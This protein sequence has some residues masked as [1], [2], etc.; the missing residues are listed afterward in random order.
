MST[1][2]ESREVTYDE[3]R[4]AIRETGVLLDQLRGLLSYPNLDTLKRDPNENLSYKDE[5][6]NLVNLATEA[7]I[8]NQDLGRQV[9]WLEEAASL[10]VGDPESIDHLKYERNLIF[11]VLR[12]IGQP[13]ALVKD[14]PNCI[15]DICHSQCR[16]PSEVGWFSALYQIGLWLPLQL[17]RPKSW[18]YNRYKLLYDRIT[19]L[20]KELEAKRE[21]ES[22][23]E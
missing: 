4:E 17:E 7:S 14:L 21:L 5:L 12:R 13:S 3:M 9:A 19:K 16:P 20:E 1:P 11:V 6:L 2:Y 10:Y 22:K 8:W 23:S 18:L 15:E